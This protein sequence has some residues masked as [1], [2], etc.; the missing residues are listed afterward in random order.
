M[1]YDVS[2]SY[3]SFGNRIVMFSIN[4]LLDEDGN[5]ICYPSKVK[6]DANAYI[7]NGGV[8]YNA[9]MRGIWHEAGFIGD[10]NNSSGTKFESLLYPYGT[11]M[12]SRGQTYETKNLARYD[13]IKSKPVLY[14]GCQAG[15]MTLEVE[16]TMGSPED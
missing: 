5:V 7:V 14:I 3:R 11:N 1:K 2:D 15:S 4:S 9:Y 10:N 13:G 6:T 16:F 12:Y 8:P